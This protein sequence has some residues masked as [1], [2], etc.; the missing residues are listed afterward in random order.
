ML[1]EAIHALIIAEQE[2]Q[3]LKDKGI[4][5]TGSYSK[6]SSVFKIFEDLITTSELETQRDEVLDVF[7]DMGIDESNLP[8]A[9]ARN[10]AKPAL[11]RLINEKFAFYLARQEFGKSPLDKPSKAYVAPFSNQQIAQ[12][13]AYD[14][15]SKYRKRANKISKKK[16]SWQRISYYTKK[17]IPKLETLFKAIDKYLKKRLRKTTKNPP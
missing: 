12:N 2:T 17:L 7:E 4:I 15:I 8:S 11:S 5:S 10:E 3:K 6:A 14:E 1:H 13:Y 16:M 9:Q